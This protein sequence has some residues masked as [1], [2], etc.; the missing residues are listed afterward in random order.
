MIAPTGLEPQLVLMSHPELTTFGA[1]SARLGRSQV[2][3]AP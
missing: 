3:G 2:I 1:S